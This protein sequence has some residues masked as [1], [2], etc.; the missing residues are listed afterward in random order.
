LILAGEFP[1]NISGVLAFDSDDFFEFAL[2]EENLVT[3]SAP[4]MESLAG[5]I[6]CP[7]FI[8]ADHSKEDS[9]MKVLYD[10]MDS[11][12][13]TYAIT[14]IFG[15]GE[16]YDFDSTLWESVTSFLNSL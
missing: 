8:T 6:E 10:S 13:K 3:I 15:I 1:E 9:P 2:D 14:N 12:N 11:D 16:L 4:S 7:V 5:D